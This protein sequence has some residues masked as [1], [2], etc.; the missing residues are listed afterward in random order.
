MLVAPLLAARN[1]LPAQNL[2]LEGD[3]GAF[4]EVVEGYGVLAWPEH[5]GDVE[6]RAAVGAASTPESTSDCLIVSSARGTLWRSRP[7][8][9]T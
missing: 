1:L 3:A 5:A 7:V 9:G 8:R 6:P 4:V 2:E